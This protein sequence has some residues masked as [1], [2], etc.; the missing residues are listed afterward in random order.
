MSSDLH[1]VDKASVMLEKEYMT[2]LTEE[3]LKKLSN[4]TRSEL[5]AAVVAEDCALLEAMNRMTREKYVQ[6]A[7]M[8]QQLTQ[9]MST[10]QKTYEDFSALV[11]HV[12]TIHQQAV[13]M[14]KIALALDEYS[15]YLESQLALAHNESE[16]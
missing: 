4:Y 15:H 2:R 16:V 11:E 14:E 8:S 5:L 3:A 13:S 6:M 12:E 1:A 10:V 7:D 9:H